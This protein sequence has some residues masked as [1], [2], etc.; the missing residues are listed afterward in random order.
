MILSSWLY[1]SWVFIYQSNKCLSPVTLSVRI[2]IIQ[3]FLMQHYVIK[4]VSDL[5]QV[6]GFLPQYNWP[7][8]YN[9][10]IFESGAKHHNPQPWITS[11][12]LP[13]NR[14]HSELFNVHRDNQWSSK[15]YVIVLMWSSDECVS[16]LN[17]ICQE[18]SSPPLIL[19]DTISREFN[20]GEA[21]F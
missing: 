12:I 19:G 18:Y 3:V 4:F 1:G 16:P 17:P 14:F 6:G 8:R 5:R 9:W 10:N 20:K 11:I 21:Y 13:V 7:P 2:T 15:V